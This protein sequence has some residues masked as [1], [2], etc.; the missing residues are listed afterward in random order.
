MKTFSGSK[1]VPRVR[2]LIGWLVGCVKD[3]D[4]PDGL[5]VFNWLIDNIWSDFLQHWKLE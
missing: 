2:W 1:K 5:E 3:Q 4:Q